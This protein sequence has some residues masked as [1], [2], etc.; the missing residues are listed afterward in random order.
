MKLGRKPRIYRPEVRSYSELRERLMLPIDLSPLP[1][2][3]DYTNGMSG[4]FGGMLN[5]QLGDC[6]C[7][8]YYHARQVWSFNAYGK[9]ITEPD[10]NVLFL[11]EQACGYN[12]TD[13]STDQGGIEQDVLTYLMKA[14]APVGDAADRNKIIS[15]IEAD[16]SNLNEV[17]RAISDCGVAYIGINVPAYIM[18]E[19]PDIWDI[20]PNADNSIVGGHAIILVGYDDMGFDFISWGKKYR[21]TVAFF[22]MEC[23][24]CYAIADPEWI[25]AT[26]KT[27]LGMSISQLE[28]EMQ[29]LK[30]AQ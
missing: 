2:S 27:P 12:P 9:E 14:G 4:R 20:A 30:N 16:V 18:N 5:D 22:Q 6:T 29:A 3:V 21:M 19:I 11:Y 8:A 26:G 10:K 17:R 23:D 24:E 28:A 15:F 13:P 25:E 7:A 1:V